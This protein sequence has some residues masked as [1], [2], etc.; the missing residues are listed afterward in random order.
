MD[1]VFRPFAKHDWLFFGGAE[2]FEMDVPVTVDICGAQAT[3][4]VKIRTEPLIADG[5][6]ISGVKFTVCCDKH[7][8]ELHFMEGPV[9]GLTREHRCYRL[10]HPMELMTAREAVSLMSRT[11]LPWACGANWERQ[12]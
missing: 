5:E 6:D 12:I 4:T 2:P 11:P 9:D 1:L 3:S 7:S 10:N 8:V